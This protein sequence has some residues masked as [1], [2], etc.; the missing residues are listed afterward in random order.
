MKKL[1]IHFSN[2]TINLHGSVFHRRAASIISAFCAVFL[3]SALVPCSVL[4]APAEETGTDYDAQAEAHREM[5]VESNEWENWPAGPA[6]SAQSA[7]L[8]DAET[9]AIL[10]EKN[11]HEQLYPASITKILTALIVMEQCPLDEMVTYSNEAVNSINWQTD[12]NIGIKAGEQITVEQSLYGLL[13]GSANEVA[14]ALAEHVSGSVDAFAELMNERAAEL[15]C[16]DSHFANANGIFDENH[17]TS[18]H[19]MALI[20]KAFF[21]N[22]LLSKISGTSTYTI[23]RSDTVSEELLITCRNQLL[24]GKSYAYE[25]LVGS[26]TGYTSEARQTLVSCAQKDGMKLICVVMKEESPSQFTD[27]IELFNY[28]FSSFHMVNVADAD[29]RYTVGNELFFEADADVF[30]SSSPLLSIDSADSIILP[31]T[32]DY[33]D[34]QSTLSYDDP[35][36]EDAVAE[37]SFTYNG[38]YVGSA[39]VRVVDQVSANSVGDSASG[40]TGDTESSNVDPSTSRIYINVRMV[41]IGVISSYLLL[42]FLVWLITLLRNYSFSSQRKDRKRRKRRHTHETIDY[43]R[44]SRKDPEGF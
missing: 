35:E 17:Y 24:P 25:Y 13:V 9:G 22:D 16:V 29:S 39:T 34:T 4:A 36:D 12:S 14:N 3:L 5:T 11:I 28:G 37:I 38:V 41:L 44:Y 2:R 8:M 21:S 19:D 27:T 43:D 26:K 20:A 10:Y 30:G 6:I 23:P 40:S 32:A 7:I 33:E 1:R 18:A 31:N 15:G 42:N